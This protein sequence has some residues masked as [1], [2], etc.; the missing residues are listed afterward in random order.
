[1]KISVFST[2]KYNLNIKQKPLFYTRLTQ[3]FAVPRWFDIELNYSYQSP[4]TSGIFGA[5]QK[6]QLDLEL[7]KQFLGGKM[8]ISILGM[9]L[10]KTVWN[11]GSTQIEGV[12]FQKRTQC[13]SL[14]RGHIATPAYEEKGHPP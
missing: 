8:D 5:G 1:M 2:P 6:H 11:I 12:L 4:L 7:R 10:L 13:V 14:G 9:D 3:T